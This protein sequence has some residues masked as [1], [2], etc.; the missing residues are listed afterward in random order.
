M[1]KKVLIANR[2]EIACR[3]IKT[4]KKMGIKSVAVYSDPDKHSLHVKVADESCRIGEAQS[5]S[6]YLNIDNIIDACKYMNV[7][8]VHPGYGFL[9][10][11]V[12]FKKRLDKEGIKFIGPNELAIDVMG[13]KIR[14][15]EVA[16]GCGVPTVPG[17]TDEIRDA[18]H[19]IKVS[20]EIGYPVMI[21]ASAGGGGKGMRIS[22]S[23]SETGESFDRA[24]SEALS[25]FGDDRIFIEKFIENPR[26]IEIQVLADSHGNCLYLAE[27][28]C[29]IQRRHQK[30]IEECPSPF[31]NS[32]Q[33]KLMGEKAVILA[34]EVN[35]VSAGT[36]EFIVDK[37]HNFY[38][39]EMNTRLQVEHPVTEMVIGIDLVESMIRIACGEKLNLKQNEI[40]IKGWAIESRIYA[41][42]P[43]RGFL[44]S[45][46][47]ITKYITPTESENVRVDTGIY[48]GGEISMYYDPMIAKLCS[49]GK[50]RSEA[51][52][53]MRDALNRYIVKGLQHN[54][55]FLSS[56]MS[57]QTFISG[58]L[59]TNFIE[60]EY[61]DGLTK[62][63]EDD[64]ALLRMVALAT[65]LNELSDHRLVINKNSNYLNQ[66]SRFFV[67]YNKK[68]YDIRIGR[69]GPCEKVLISNDLPN[70]ADVKINN[71][72]FNFC[73]YWDF[74]SS[75]VKVLINKEELFF[76]IQKAVFGYKIYNNG[77]E[78]YPKILPY[79]NAHLQE[80]MPEKV[81]QDRSNFLISPMPGLLVSINVKVGQS[82][83]E[84]ESLV[85]V[86]AMKMEN[87]LRAERDVIIKSI[88]QNTGCSLAVDEVIMEFE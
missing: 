24:R 44:P 71:E 87:V 30:V 84:G 16:K 4:L 20:N 17:N 37:D 61:P 82:V 3:I 74:F 77:F 2:G 35:Y 31:I 64:T 8:A 79:R 57:N 13:D 72:E 36:V 49:W 63:E 46:G 38:F 54:I 68:K 6:S 12:E 60:N 14:S 62:Y 75:I 11:N 18:K 65:L 32:T 9:S 41:E 19:A 56:I 73:I 22:Y 76:Q 23:D 53:F 26:H 27:R 25:S 55:P 83:K 80:H 59:S 86:E 45:T 29:S 50:N 85:V 43:F 47:R 28:E 15:K 34:K 39:L 58:D 48:E 67:E 33:R 66:N 70:I 81:D 51:L 7:D 88:K 5:S 40:K 1:F 10:E 52:E 69:E 21:K 42:D 78:I